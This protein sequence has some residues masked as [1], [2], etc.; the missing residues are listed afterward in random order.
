VDC[1]VFYPTVSYISMR[2]RYVTRRPS[3]FDTVTFETSYG[4]IRV[5]GDPER[6]LT[7]DY[8]AGWRS[9]VPPPK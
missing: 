9:I 1:H 6:Y 2:S 5:P 8:G 7:D 4:R 3:V